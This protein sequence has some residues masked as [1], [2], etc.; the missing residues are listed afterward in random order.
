MSRT[1]P[2]TEPDPPP[3][4]PFQGGGAQPGSPY[5]PT[6][7]AAAPSA[8]PAARSYRLL[9]APAPLPEREGLGVGRLARVANV[10]RS[11]DRPTPNPSLP[12]RGAQPGLPCQ[13]TTRAAAPSASPAARSYRLL[14][15]PAPL[16]E[17][18]GLGVGR[19]ARVANV[20]RSGDRPTPNPSLPGRGAQP[21]LPCQPTTRAAAP[22]ASPA[23]RSYRLLPAP[24]PL[25]EREGLGVGRL[26]R[27]ANVA[28]SGDRPTPNPSLPGRGAQPGLPCQPTTRA[29]APSASPAARSYRLLPAP[30]PLPGREGLGV[31]R[32]ARVAK[33]VRYGDRPTPD[34]SLSG[35]GA[36]RAHTSTGAVSRSASPNTRR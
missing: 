7:R 24:A 10:A 25:P 30:A 22:S 33:V 21:G 4:P 1:S 6:T 31:G 2:D 23:A 26:A 34:P 12:G 28:R 36:E 29:A 17:R 5:Q 27:V 19:L 15:A 3:T 35:R 16:P 18:E 11:G 20:A 8:S 13:P 9:P 32:S 14:P